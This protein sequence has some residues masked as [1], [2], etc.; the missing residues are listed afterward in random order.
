MN[1]RGAYVLDA[2][3]DRQKQAWLDGS[4]PSVDEI[5]RSSSLAPDPEV[6]LDLIYNEIVLREELGHRPALEDYSGRYPQLLDDL[7]LHFEVHR[8]LQ[9]KV[10]LDTRRVHEDESL[11]DLDNV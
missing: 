11:D 6:L 9:E 1:N 10:L 7:K 8:V 4:H 5:L 3:L 2:V